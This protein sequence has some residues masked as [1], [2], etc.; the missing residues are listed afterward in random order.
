[1]LTSAD[2]VA[3]VEGGGEKEGERRRVGAE[4]EKAAL[5][6]P[7]RFAFFSVNENPQ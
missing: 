7:F 6:F 3:S 2:R 4:G 1:M 5:S